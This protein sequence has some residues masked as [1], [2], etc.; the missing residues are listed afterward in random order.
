MKKQKF[1]PGQLVTGNLY[2]RQRDQVLYGAV[3]TLIERWW[4]WPFTWKVLHNGQIIPV[5]EEEF[6]IVKEDT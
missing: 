4:G 6:R 1:K 2:D 5:C 3:A